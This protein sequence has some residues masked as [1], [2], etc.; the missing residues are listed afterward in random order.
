MY[1]NSR[2]SG[3]RWHPIPPRCQSRRPQRRSPHGWPEVRHRRHPDLAALRVV[4]RAIRVED[5]RRTSNGHTTLHLEIFE[6]IGP[7]ADIPGV[8]RRTSPRVM[9][10]VMDTF[11]MRK[12]YVEPAKRGDWQAHPAG[13]VKRPCRG[14]RGSVVRYARDV[15][16]SRA[17]PAGTARSP[18]R[19][20]ATSAQTL[21]GC[22]MRQGRGWSR[23]Q[24]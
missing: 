22:C 14:H 13:W 12:G 11:S 2:G 19:G 6:L 9:A 24:M 5:V 23:F 4:S 10:W 7:T 1:D 3:K 17:R 15:E 20:S 21:P 8:G 18:S 16:A